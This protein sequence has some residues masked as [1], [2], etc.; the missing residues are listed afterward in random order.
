MTPE[1]KEK[2]KNLPA[3]P[4]VYLM[5]DS[6]SGIIYVGK[7]RSLRQRV[8]SYFQAARHL[9]PKT[10]ALVEQIVDLDFIVTD[11]EVEAL[12]LE[13]NLIKYY[14]P[15]YNIS[16]KDDKHYPYLKVTLEEEF[17]RVV[18][19]RSIKKDKGRYFG[20]YTDVGAMRETM[21]LMEGIF[22]L[23][24]CKQKVLTQRSRPCLN[25]HIQRCLAPCSGQVAA[26]A[27]R[28][29]VQQAIM[30][31]EGR[32]EPLVRDLTRQMEAAAADLHF[33]QAARLRDQ[34]LALQAVTE[35]QKII[36]VGMEDQ[37]VLGIALGV[38]EAAG[39]VFFVRGGK[40]VGRE[41]FWLR[42]TDGL[43]L[44]RVLL[45]FIKQYYAA[46]EAVPATVLLPVPL[47]ADESQ[48]IEQWL[49]GKRSGPK[50]RL[51]VPQRG[52]KLKLIELAAKNTALTLEEQDRLAENRRQGIL[53]ALN[54]L[55]QKLNLPALPSRIEGYDISNT[56]GE[57][58]VGSM[59]VIE[60]GEP[61]KAAYRR[62]QIKTVVG[63]N[64][65]AS[66]QEVLRRRFQ[67]G[68]AESQSLAAGEIGEEQAP[69]AR[70][71]DLLIVDGGKGQLSAA[72]EIM[73]DLG[74]ESIPTFGLAKEH[75]Y[76]FAEAQ[77]DPIIL[78]PDSPE[79]HLL[80]RLRDEAHRFALTYHRKKRDKASLSSVLNEIPGIGP[81]RRKA[82]LKHFGSVKGIREA[83]LADL[84][85]VPGLNSSSA[86]AVWDFFAGQRL[87]VK[88]QPAKE[89]VAT[90][91]ER[92]VKEAA[93]GVKEPAVTEPV[94][95][96]RE[97]ATEVKERTA[98]EQ[99]AKEAGNTGPIDET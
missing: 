21:R 50:V 72:R 35:K 83:E 75:E 78:P 10:Q 44:D 76:L 49:T 85:A 17:P 40:M 26:E 58:S 30:F 97:S 86:Q 74:V 13:C 22:A 94:A 95:A 47:P 11:S 2:L 7:A 42:N 28:E 18:V 84:L 20:P 56:Q 81:K 12:I 53:V 27:Y 34:I 24:S 93:A 68:L 61:C 55:Q 92:T 51:K 3:S 71:P 99:P 36:S 63:P 32:I 73:R 54:G 82:L 57:A 87:A 98:K 38:R 45:E 19:V 37:D 60:D 64:D 1:I 88:E 33:E 14:R 52:G 43:P 70:F 6:R 8:R 41:T 4:G 65:Y 5:K 67:R 48:L 23:R 69:F 9:D 66:L 25:Y 96:V 59:V 90:V 16:L 39:Q 46:V 29:I 79:L 89:P 77:T 15:K 80:Q 91:K 31:L 62:F